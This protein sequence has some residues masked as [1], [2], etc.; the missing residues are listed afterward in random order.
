MADE[1]ERRV[2][3]AAKPQAGDGRTLFASAAYR[4]WIVQASAPTRH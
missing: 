4:L 2:M 1:F 3:A